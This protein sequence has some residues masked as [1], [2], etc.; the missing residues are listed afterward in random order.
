[1]IAKKVAEET[2]ATIRNNKNIIAE[3]GKKISDMEEFIKLVD[4]R[5]K[6][7]EVLSDTYEK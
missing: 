6:D 1:M 3:E 4:Q 2:L 7:I 5:K